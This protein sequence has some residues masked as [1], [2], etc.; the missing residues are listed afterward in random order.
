MF[1]A[2]GTRPCEARGNLGIMRD[3]QGESK[4]ALDLYKQAKACGA[5]A[6]KL[7]ESID[8]KERLFGGGQ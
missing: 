6:P 7:N 2:L 8:V 5:H 4:K 1:D 3:R